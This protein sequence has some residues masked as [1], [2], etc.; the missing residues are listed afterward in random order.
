[1]YNVTI[2]LF[3][4]V[5]ICRNSVSSSVESVDKD[6]FESGLCMVMVNHLEIRVKKLEASGEKQVTFKKN[7]KKL[8]IKKYI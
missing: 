1:M 7:T 5:L 3:I 2:V 8:N 4:L 6:D